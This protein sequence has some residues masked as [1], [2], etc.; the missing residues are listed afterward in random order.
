[1]LVIENCNSLS[2]LRQKLIDG[3][4]VRTVR[5]EPCKDAISKTEVIK[6]IDEREDANGK[7]DAESIRTD[8]VLMLPV[9]PQTICEEREKGECP[10]YAG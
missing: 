4:E 5:Q 3:E 1:M 8:I 10:Y 6:A 2:E 7:V 9:N